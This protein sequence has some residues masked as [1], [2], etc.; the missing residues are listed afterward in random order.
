MRSTLLVSES[1]STHIIDQQADEDSAHRLYNS[2][3]PTLVGPNDVRVYRPAGGQSV[4]LYHSGSGAVEL[5]DSDG[6]TLATFNDPE[7]V[8]SDLTAYLAT[9]NDIEDFEEWSVVKRPV[10]PTVAFGEGGLDSGTWSTWSKY[11]ERAMASCGSSRTAA[12]AGSRSASWSTTAR[13]KTVR[14]KRA[15]LVL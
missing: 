6:D 8:F 1:G 9:E 14:S 10:I 13:A 3:G 7:D 2:N 12:T 4:W 11:Q 5:R 15:G